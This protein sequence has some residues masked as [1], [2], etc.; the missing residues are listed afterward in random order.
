[1]EME[2]LNLTADRDVGLT[3]IQCDSLAHYWIFYPQYQRIIREK[4]N[5]NGL[6][7]YM[8]LQRRKKRQRSFDKNHV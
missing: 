2:N 1:M 5:N 4:T 6:A 7:L 8:C 3:Q